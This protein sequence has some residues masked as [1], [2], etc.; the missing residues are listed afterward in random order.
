MRRALLPVILLFAAT[1]HALGAFERNDP[2]VQEG[3]TAYQRG[4][5][6]AALKAFDEARKNPALKDS[7]TLEFNRGN[8][9]YK[10]GRLEDAKKAYH[11]VVESEQGPLREKDYYNLGNA[12]AQL[13][14]KKEAVSAYRRALTLDPNDEAARHNLEVVLRDLKP[15]QQKQNGDGGQDGGSDGGRDGG[16]DG[17]RD[18]G[19]DGGQGD[20]GLDGGHGDGGSDGGQ[21]DGGQDGGKGTGAPS[22]E[23][24]D[25]GSDGGQDGGH[26][27]NAKPEGMDAGESSAAEEGLEDGGVA[28]GKLNKSDVD[29]LLN[30]MKQSERSLQMWRFQ[31]KKKQRKPNEKDW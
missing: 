12:W 5:Y 30:A 13:K 3:L 25:G 26:G 18:G 15:P 9:L 24:G 7:A 6:E 29:R 16:L 14:D 22:S 20:G 19:T 10:L 8:A 17:G 27:D 1:G 23:G 2:K 4:D 11:Q 21:G 28:E 31:Q